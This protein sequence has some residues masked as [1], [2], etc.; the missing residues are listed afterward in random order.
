MIISVWG[1]IFLGLL[2]LFFSLKAVTLFPDLE[3]SEHWKFNVPDIE[4]KYAAKASQC[5]IA[6]GIYTVTFIVVW[7]QNRY[8]PPLL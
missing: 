5:W 4:E 6:A 3:F 2:G 8:N 1:I 7:F